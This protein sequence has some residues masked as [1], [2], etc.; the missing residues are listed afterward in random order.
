VI[1][2]WNA[3]G[4]TRG[5][6][7]FANWLACTL[8][9]KRPRMGQN[10]VKFSIR[11]SMPDHP[12]PKPIEWVGWLVWRLAEKGDTILDPFLGS[13]TTL[14]ACYRLG[15]QGVGIEISEEYCELAATRLEREIAQGRLF[16]P[17][18]TA[19]KPVQTTLEVRP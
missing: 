11:G 7:G 17:A 3:R 4:M 6:I 16:E 18:E 12:T 10:F 15:R 8:F 19:P 13:G 1:A 2:G 14:V 5:R 9:G